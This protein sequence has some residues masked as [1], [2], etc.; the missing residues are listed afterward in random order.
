MDREPAPAA[1]AGSGARGGEAG[2][3]V[4]DPMEPMTRGEGAVAEEAGMAVVAD[5]DEAGAPVA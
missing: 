1:G 3:E 2:A 4:G 5:P